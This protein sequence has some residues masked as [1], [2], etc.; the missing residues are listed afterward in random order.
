MSDGDLYFEESGD[1]LR[2]EEYPDEESLDG[3]DH[4]E[5][6]DYTIACPQCGADVYDDV[7]RCP[8]CGDYITHDTG[9][10]SDRPWWWIALGLLGAL[11]AILALAT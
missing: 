11:A 9:P 5:S 1:E 6:D 3:G 7:V 2:Y 8:H 10:W 4:D